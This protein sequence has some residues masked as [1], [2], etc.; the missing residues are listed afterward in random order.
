MPTWVYVRSG[1]VNR[2][3]PPSSS[4]KRCLIV[5]IAP[6]WMAWPRPD[7]WAISGMAS[8]RLWRSSLSGRVVRVG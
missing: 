1:N 8:E 3:V 5:L 6:S 7:G 2:D 4:E